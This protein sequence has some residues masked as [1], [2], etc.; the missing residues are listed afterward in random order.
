MRPRNLDRGRI[1][2]QRVTP[3]MTAQVWLLLGAVV[4]ITA[5][6]PTPVAGLR[7]AAL[8]LALVIPGYA[9]LYVVFGR[10]LRPDPIPVVALSILL[11][12]AVY[13]LL[14]LILSALSIGISPG[15]ETAGTD[16][17]ILALIGLFVLR[18]WNGETPA[19]WQLPPTETPEPMLRRMPPEELYLQSEERSPLRPTRRNSGWAAAYVGG[20]VLS[21]IV[22]IVTLHYTA[23][24]ED[25]AFT[26]FY[27]AGSSAHLGNI[28]DVPTGAS[29]A[30]MVGITNHTHQAQTYRIL[31][32]LDTGIRWPGRE[33]RLAAGRAW[34]GVLNGPVTMDN[35]THRLVLQLSTPQNNGTVATLIVWV[36]GTAKAGTA[37]VVPHG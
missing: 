1:R 25:V 7:V 23:K 4:V 6:G 8:P 22:L 10:N 5:L 21:I 36:R 14:A 3:L 11:S 2:P 15:S 32:T 35:C 33:I 19:D 37:C 12:L 13:A 30:L 34:S 29:L 18:K 20:T 28:V 17:F 9:V 16:C 24:P 26:Q 31:P 27:L